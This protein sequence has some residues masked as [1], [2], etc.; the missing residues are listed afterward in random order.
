VSL[1]VGEWAHAP[2]V[3]L[4]LAIGYA[5]AWATESFFLATPERNIFPALKCTSD[6]LVT[7]HVPYLVFVPANLHFT[8]QQM[9]QLFNV[10]RVF[11]LSYGFEYVSDVS[12]EPGTS[13]VRAEVSG[14]Q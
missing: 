11:V 3:L 10:D 9:L 6:F 8:W 4:P 7:Q 5:A 1:G 14:K 13:I 12:G 2:S